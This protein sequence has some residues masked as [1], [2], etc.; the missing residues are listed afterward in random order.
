MGI[1]STGD[2]MIKIIIILMNKRYCSDFSSVVVYCGEYCS[3]VMRWTHS[4]AQMLGFM[5]SL[6]RSAVAPSPPPMMLLGEW[7]SGRAQRCVL[8]QVRGHVVC[9][10]S[11]RLQWTC[12]LCG[13]IFR[14]VLI[15][16][17]VKTLQGDVTSLLFKRLLDLHENKHCLC[18]VVFIC[19]DCCL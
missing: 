10:L 15:I 3:T 18:S 1:K 19:C 2:F 5:F 4:P 11:L 17:T 16:H 8:A 13:S 14:Q 7:A 6:C 9:V 12:S